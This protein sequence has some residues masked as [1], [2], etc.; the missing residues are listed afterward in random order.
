MSLQISAKI[1]TNFCFATKQHKLQQILLQSW[2][3]C[4]KT[5]L[6]PYDRFFPYFPQIICLHITVFLH[7]HRLWQITGMYIRD[8]LCLQSWFFRVNKLAGLEATLVETLPSD[9]VAGAKRRATSVAKNTGLKEGLDWMKGNTYHVKSSKRE[10]EGT[11]LSVLSVTLFLSQSL[12]VNPR[13]VKCLQIKRCS[14]RIHYICWRRFQEVQNWDALGSLSIS[15]GF[16]T[17]LFLFR[18]L[19]HPH[20][21]ISSQQMI[22]IPPDQVYM[23]VNQH[24]VSFPNWDWLELIV[25]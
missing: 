2:I 6:S 19:C 11:C 23:W 4:D 8:I 24:S 20:S 1:A 10:L 14:W 9:W 3:N 25:L 5:V 13:V 12:K 22:L 17:K 15:E 18:F 21:T 7:K 16:S